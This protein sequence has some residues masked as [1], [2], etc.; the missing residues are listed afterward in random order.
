MLSSASLFSIFDIICIHLGAFISFK[1]SF[2]S[3]IF[4][5]FLTKLIAIKFTH[6]ETAN[7]KSSLSLSVIQGNFNLTHGKFKCLFD[8]II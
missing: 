1:N 3:S 7:F 4:S 6:I 8:Q 2:I 5:L